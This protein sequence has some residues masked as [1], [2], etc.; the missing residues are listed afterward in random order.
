MPATEVMD[1]LGIPL[2]CDAFPYEKR[3][4]SAQLYQRGNGWAVLASGFVNLF[5]RDPGDLIDEWTLGFDFRRVT[6]SQ[7]ERDIVGK[8]TKRPHIDYFD[9]YDTSFDHISHHNNDNASR[10]RELK[11]LDL[12]IGRIWMAMQA[13]SRADE[14]ALVLVSD[15]GF[16][17]DERV[18]SQGF[19]L[20]RLLGSSGGGGHHVVT[21]R[22]LLL[23]YSL[24]GLYPSCRSF[25]PNRRNPITSR[26]NIPLI[27]LLLDFDGNE[28]SSIHLRESDLNVLHILP[29]QLQRRS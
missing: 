8:L 22:R 11:K 4:T 17:S 9:Y 19:N 1:Q 14:T 23:D 25:E 12:T 5:P 15:H 10:L 27:R 16:N 28:R 26:A 21:K 2:L 13:S 24:K 29:Q 6:V 18:Y 20:V 3:Y 7:N